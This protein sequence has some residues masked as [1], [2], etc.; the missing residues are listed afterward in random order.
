[1]EYIIR[2]V[3]DYLLARAW[4]TTQIYPPLETIVRQINM[5]ILWF[6][7]Q[8]VIFRVPLSTLQKSEEEGGWGLVNPE[9]KC[10]AL[11]LYRMREQVMKVGAVTADWMQRWGCTCRR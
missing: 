3:H 1:M 10:Q 2:Y 5:I 4:Y 11:L 7:W 9:A 6:L 8:G